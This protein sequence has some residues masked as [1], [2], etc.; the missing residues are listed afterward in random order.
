M[1][2][3]GKIIDVGSQDSWM[4]VTVVL[5]M[6]GIVL[7]FI[8]LSCIPGFPLVKWDSSHDWNLILRLINFFFLSFIFWPILVTQNLLNYYAFNN[9]PFSIH[10]ILNAKIIIS[11]L[12]IFHSN[13]INGENCELKRRLWFIVLY[14]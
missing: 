12:N 3:E 5:T 14:F 9:P 1:I 10:H 4:L 8:W 7:P 6:S 11:C 2:I 13:Y